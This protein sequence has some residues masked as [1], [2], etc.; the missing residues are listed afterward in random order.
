MELTAIDP[1]TGKVL[2]SQQ[3]F[4]SKDSFRKTLVSMLPDLDMS[5]VTIVADGVMEGQEGEPKPSPKGVIWRGPFFD[6][7]GYANMN[8]EISLGLVRHGFQVK[9]DP[10]QTAPQAD[11]ETTRTI[12]LLSHTKLKDEGLCPMVV[13]FTPMPIQRP[14]RRTVFFTMMETR[15]L[16]PEFVARCNRYSTEV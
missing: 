4:L 9:L 2:L 10:L 12:V 3:G 13:G 14:G 15:R 5:Q 1:K 16:H 11:P 6:L 7:G 8:R